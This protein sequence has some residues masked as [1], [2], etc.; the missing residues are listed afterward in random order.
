MSALSALVG[1][2]FSLIGTKLHAAYEKRGEEGYSVLLIP[3]AQEADNGISIGKVIE[4]IKKLVSGTGSEAN[5]EEMEG[6]LTGSLSGLQEDGGNFDL[7]K[8]IVKLNM[9]YLY[10]NKGKDPAED[11]LEYAFQ[12]QIITEGFI[13]KE[14]AQIV[15]VSNLSLSV[16]NTSRKKVVDQMQLI[17]VDEYLGIASGIEDKKSDE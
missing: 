17:T 8:I 5:T 7:N 1:I 3:T 9:A 6:D 11:V 13:P 10:I 2:D 14:I 16:W 15:D 4:D 12:L